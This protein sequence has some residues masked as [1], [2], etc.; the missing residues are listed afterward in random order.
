MP[1]STDIV[2]WKDRSLAR[3]N[4]VEA[5]LFLLHLWLCGAFG[6]GGSWGNNA[7]SNVMRYHV[8][9]MTVHAKLDWSTHTARSQ[10]GKKE[11][12]WNHDSFRSVFQ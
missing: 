3:E 6:G 9:N 2:H 11:I 7:S 4:H 8:T 10:L 1:N 5:R 12:T